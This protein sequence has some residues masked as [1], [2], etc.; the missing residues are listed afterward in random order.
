MCDIIKQVMGKYLKRLGVL[1]LAAVFSI[2]LLGGSVFAV[3]ED[4]DTNPTPETSEEETTEESTT[5]QPTCYDEVGGIGWL[6]CPG[7]SFLANII[8]GAYGILEELINVE[9]VSMDQDAPIHVVWN[10]LRNI[11]NIA[12]VI[13]FLIIIYSQITGVGI[14]NYGI[15]RMLPRLIIAAILLNISYI[16]CALAVD[17]SNVAGNG[18]RSIFVTIGEE[19]LANGTVS[20]TAASTSVAGIVATILGVGTAGT[21]GALAIT[22]GFSGLIWLLLP[23]ILSGA[24]AVISALVTMAARQALIIL[25]VMISPAAFVAYLLPNTEKWFQ[26]WLNIFISM[27]IFYPMFSVLYGASNL[28]GL[29]MITS[30]TNWL[31]VVLGIA[32]MVLPLFM[33]I[34]LLRMSGTV[35][36]AIDGRI[37]RATAPAEN[38][39]RGMALENRRLAKARQLSSTSYRPSTRLAKYLNQRRVDRANDLAD[40]TKTADDMA[41]A[42]S[43]T[44][45]F[46]SQ[47]RLNRRGVRYYNNQQLRMRAQN[48]IDKF[49]IDMDEG[50]EGDDLAHVRARDKARIDAANAGY[51]QAITEGAINASRKRVVN[52]ENLKRRAETIQEGLAN[53]DSEISRQV[54]QSFNYQHQSTVDYAAITT[55]EREA[56]DKTASRAINAVLSDAITAK[57]KADAE[58]RGIYTELYNDL[59]AG[60]QIRENL[61]KSFR[62][63]DYNS[64]TAAIDVMAKRGDYDAITEVLIEHS[65]DIANDDRVQKQLADTLITMKKDDA[66]LWSWSKALMMRRGMNGSGKEIEAYV[67]F[68]DYLTGAEL[69]GDIDDSAAKKVARTTLI[70]NIGDPGIGKTQD[71]TFWKSIQDAR[72]KGYITDVKDLGLSMKQIRSTAASG[73]VDGETLA[74]INSLLTGGAEKV[75]DNTANAQEL[76]YFNANR[77]G[78][79]QN[80]IEYLKDMSAGQLVTSK[81]STMSALN[82]LLKYLEPDRIMVNANGD[83][84][85]E[86]FYHLFDNQRNALNK[87]SATS[88]RATMNPAIRKM[89]DIDLD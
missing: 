20:D 44:R 6:V 1:L 65:G 9:P 24:I 39:L 11:S 83:A 3:P 60:P 15:K 58:A 85:S 51:K 18:L 32:V 12:F 69:A 87:P 63:K 77:D 62:T 71:R 16:V 13:V 43:R 74:T 19:A 21:I 49:D 75:I 27:L 66:L 86:T 37:R 14:S 72:V 2:F 40:A 35:L 89:L 70:P 45:H 56:Y 67:S 50:F 33:S 82:N 55:A 17:V 52:M 76:A 84:V 88:Q 59:P 80:V 26:K 42:T 53:A 48:T 23:I 79:K 8:D 36:G 25:L 38:S 7:T 73:T 47:G 5:E 31:G 54:A 10:Y 46:D 34:S 30:A 81:S 28:A 68:S 61:K 64:M 4:T 78:I 41:N 57:R 29:V 22:G